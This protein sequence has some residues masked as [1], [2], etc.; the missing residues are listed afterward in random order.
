[1]LYVLGNKFYIISNNKED[2]MLNEWLSEFL[3]ELFLPSQIQIVDAS[4]FIDTMLLGLL[5]I[6]WLV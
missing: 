6:N 4:Q 2:F 3:L 1:M 5:V